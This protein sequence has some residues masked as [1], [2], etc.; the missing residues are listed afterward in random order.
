[1]TLTRIN[2]N[3]HVVRANKK[4]GKDDPPIRI[5]R[6]RKVTYAREVKVGEGRFV[7]SPDKPLGCGA[8]LWFET[9]EEV[10]VVA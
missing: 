1:M 10:Q 8:R 5:S 4:H 7:Y 6:G 2:V 3:A 9:E